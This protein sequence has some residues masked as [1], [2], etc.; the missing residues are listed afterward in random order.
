MASFLSCGHSA[1]ADTIFGQ[2]NDIKTNGFLLVSEENTNPR[3]LRNIESNEKYLRARITDSEER[4]FNFKLDNSNFKF[5]TLANRVVKN[6]DWVGK[7]AAMTIFKYMHWRGATREDV[8]AYFRIGGE[9]EEV[10][11]KDE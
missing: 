6:R 4:G 10:A 7:E 1:S 9:G 8:R 2:A 11:L 3:D 5:D